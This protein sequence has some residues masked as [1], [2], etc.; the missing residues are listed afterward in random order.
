M[1]IPILNVI[2]LF[3]KK[4]QL[5]NFHKK[6]YIIK[7]FISIF[8]SLLVCSNMSL[9]NTD[10]YKTLFDLAFKKNNIKIDMR[11]DLSSPQKNDN[12]IRKVNGGKITSFKAR[13]LITQNTSSDSGLNSTID[14]TPK[15]VKDLDK[16]DEIKTKS[17]ESELFDNKIDLSNRATKDPVEEVRKDLNGSKNTESSGVIKDESILSNGSSENYNSEDV[18]ANTEDGIVVKNS[19]SYKKSGLNIGV[20]MP[21]VRH[22]TMSPGSKKFGGDDVEIAISPLFDVIIQMPDQ[23]EYFRSSNNILSVQTIPGNLNMV[24]LKLNPVKNLAP[25]SLHLIDVNQNIY[26]FTVIGLPAD[27]SYEYPKTI[28]VNKRSAKK[29]TIGSQNPDSI[30]DAMD[31]DDAIQVTV[32]DIP[33]TQEYEAELVSFKYQHYEGYA[34]YGFRIYRKDQSNVNLSDVTFT[35]WADDKRLDGG[36]SYRTSR[37]VEWTIQP[38][39]TN[40]ET[41]R[42]G[43]TVLRVFLQITASILDVEEWKNTFITIADKDGYTRFD[44]KPISRPIRP[45]KDYENND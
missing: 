13:E 14:E 42:R 7:N 33:K 40:R 2:I 11:R 18:N 39:L 17:I 3:I 41:K 38:I 30:F 5:V 4:G 36:P 6:T 23:I 12:S 26:T 28:L 45:P 43:Y 15:E 27:L 32:G 35:V 20:E 44:F 24:A 16:K 10:T 31:I 37:E 8:I 9:A 21:S 34:Q 29:T 1:V 22:I 19:S 25:M